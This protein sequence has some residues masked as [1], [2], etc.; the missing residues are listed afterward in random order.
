MITGELFTEAPE[1]RLTPLASMFGLTI[2]TAWSGGVCATA[3][4]LKKNM[5]LAVTIAANKV[6]KARIVSPPDSALD[7]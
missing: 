1:G 6:D 3:L 7:R 2:G 5:R 4:A